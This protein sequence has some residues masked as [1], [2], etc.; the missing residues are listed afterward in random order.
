MTVFFVLVAL[1]RCSTCIPSRERESNSRG[2]GRKQ[3]GAERAQK[4]LSKLRNS[5]ERHFGILASSGRNVSSRRKS[6]DNCRD[7]FPSRRESGHFSAA[8]IGHI[9][10]FLGD[11]DAVVRA[12]GH[13]ADV[14]M[15]FPFL[16]EK[17]SS[18]WPKN[19]EGIKME[20]G[21]IETS[22]PEKR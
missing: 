10:A 8:F 14:L 20:G 11:K 21:L 17:I 2:R 16:A 19:V 5:P 22:S 7:S 13:L 18:A 1:F 6:S 3:S 4:G 12:R 9:L 15:V